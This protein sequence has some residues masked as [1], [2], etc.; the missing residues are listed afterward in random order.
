MISIKEVA[1]VL[2]D[3]IKATWEDLFSLMLMN[4]VTVLPIILAVLLSFAMAW[5]WEA[6]YQTLAMILLA[7]GGLLP[8]LL[9][10]PAIAGLWNTANRLVEGLAIHWSDYWEGFRRYFWKSLALAL[11]NV[12]TLAILGANVWFY[13]PGNNPWGLDSGLSSAIQIFFV[14]LIALWLIYQMYPLAMLLEQTDQRLRTALRNAGVLLITR[15]GFAILLGLALA[16][17]IAISTYLIVLWFL[18]TL[19]L[20]AV[21][22]NKAVKH[23]L[24]PYRERAAEAE[25]ENR[26]EPLEEDESEIVTRLE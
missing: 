24:I 4:L 13:A 25:D 26:D 18:I 17:V 23:L 5:A 20:I 9:L 22:C 7:T 6:G 10:P 16:V 8:L 19:P 1:N 15:P 12:V 14:I 21:V 11:V 2:W 3:S